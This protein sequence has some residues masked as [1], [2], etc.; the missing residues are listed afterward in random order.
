MTR[1]TF[2]VYDLKMCLQDSIQGLKN[3]K[4]DYSME[5]ITCA[6]LGCPSS[7][8]GGGPPDWLAIAHA[9]IC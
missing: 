5:I 9:E 7:S 4:A 1:F 3:V 6:E 2:V 8:S